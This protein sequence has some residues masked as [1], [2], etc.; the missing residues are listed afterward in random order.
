MDNQRS[1]SFSELV[2]LCSV[3]ANNT[4]YEGDNPVYNDA[5]FSD[6]DKLQ[7]LYWSTHYDMHVC[8]LCL[9][10][11]IDIDRDCI[12]DDVDQERDQDR[13]EMGF[14]RTYTKNTID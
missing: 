1:D 6:S 4:G 5:D 10:Q 8:Q 2:G 11:G 14:V 12:R 9:K 13:Q 3:C 7:P